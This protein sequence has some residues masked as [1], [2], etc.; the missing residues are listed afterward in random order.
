MKTTIGNLTK[1]LDI[2]I[3]IV[4]IIM[5]IYIYYIV[6]QRGHGFHSYVSLPEA[7]SRNLAK[8]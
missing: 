5:Y 4:Y 6:D 3:F 8:K 2:S 7:L 1:L